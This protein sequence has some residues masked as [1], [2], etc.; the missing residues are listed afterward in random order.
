MEAGEESD[1]TGSSMLVF[2]VEANLGSNRLDEG[3]CMV[4][5]ARALRNSDFCSI[6]MSKTW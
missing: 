4:D 3:V 6:K 5:L 2:K 1:Q